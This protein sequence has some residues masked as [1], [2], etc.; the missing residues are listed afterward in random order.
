MDVLQGAEVFD[1]DSLV[2]RGRDLPNTSAVY[3]IYLQH[4][5]R[6]LELTGYF[7]DASRLPAREGDH[8]HMY[9]G[10]SAEWGTRV[11]RH[12]TGD[13]WSSNWRRTLHALE[14][15]FKGLSRATGAQLTNDEGLTAWLRKVALVAVCES[16]A[17]FEL[18]AQLLMS[19]V[20]PL[21]I[22]RRRTSP[23]ARRLIAAR[24]AQFPRHQ[25]V[26]FSY[27]RPQSP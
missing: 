20:S 21:N 4:A 17:P 16:D 5:D 18:E 9:T 26:P 10:A 19:E 12:L 1:A 15:Q 11:R 2:R 3:L 13:A 6:I 27:T 22:D 25:S 23:Y 8:F 14:G 7:D 24:N